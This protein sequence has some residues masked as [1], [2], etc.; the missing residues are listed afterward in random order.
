MRRPDRLLAAFPAGT[1]KQTTH[2]IALSMR[3]LVAAAV[4]TGLVVLA[5]QL[6][7]VRGNAEDAMIVSAAAS[8]EGHSLF[9]QNCAH[10]HGLNAITGL[11]ERNLRRLLVRYG[12]KMPTVFRTTV[13]R[14]RTD[15]GMPS[16]D[17]VLG[18]DVIS[19]IYSY[20]ET[21]QDKQ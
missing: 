10:C 12:D 9:N 7:A 2:K 18:E 6:S 8:E 13:T 3:T 21:V 16:W 4:M 20:L 1:V 14:G 17:G 15:K 19:R 11:S 5:L